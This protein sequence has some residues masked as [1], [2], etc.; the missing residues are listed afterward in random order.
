[1]ALKQPG[2]EREP[3]AAIV[4]AQRRALK[5]G[6]PELRLRAFGYD[7]DNMKARFWVSAI[8]PLILFDDEDEE[9]RKQLTLLSTSLVEAARIAALALTGAVESSWFD[10][11]KDMPGKVV[12]PKQQLW[13]ETEPLFFDRIRLAVVGGLSLETVSDMRRN[14][15]APLRDI[16]LDIFDRHCPLE[17]APVTALRRY[18]NAR[19]SL[20]RTLNG[21]WKL[22][23]QLFDALNLPHPVVGSP[24]GKTRSPKK[25]VRA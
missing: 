16:V 24:V 5:V 14:F 12:V 4:H 13:Q 25:R 2:G 11:P 1:M 19:Y 8:Q 23:G 7:M 22:G 3:A 20:L 17:S 18:V 15:Q 9:K 10:R 6:I 21:Y